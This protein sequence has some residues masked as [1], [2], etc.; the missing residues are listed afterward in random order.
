MLSPDTERTQPRYLDP[1]LITI[2]AVLMLAIGYIAS[3]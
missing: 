1:A 3:L 2:A